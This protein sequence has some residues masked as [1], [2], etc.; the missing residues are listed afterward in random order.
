MKKIGKRVG[1]VVAAPVVAPVAV[2]VGVAAACVVIVGAPFYFGF[3]LCK[4][5]F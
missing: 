5:L 1:M 4:K 3:R 2:G